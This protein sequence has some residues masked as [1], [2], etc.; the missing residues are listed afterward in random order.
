MDVVANNTPMMVDLNARL[1]EVNAVVYLSNFW[2]TGNFAPVIA[3]A[4]MD[5]VVNNIP[6][7]VDLNVRLAAANVV[8][9]QA[10]TI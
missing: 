3:N 9:L 10:T 6:M 5:A 2:V 7:M 1:E 8:A 4:L